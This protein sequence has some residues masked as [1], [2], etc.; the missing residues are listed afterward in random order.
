MEKKKKRKS[1]KER[2]KEFL[3]EGYRFWDFYRLKRSFVKP[4]AQDATNTIIQSITVTPSTLN[5]IFPI[6]Q[7]EI[8]VNP[9]IT[10]NTGY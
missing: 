7:D 6:P 8:L 5:I 4:Q 9:N 10:Q 3:F 2:R 1:P